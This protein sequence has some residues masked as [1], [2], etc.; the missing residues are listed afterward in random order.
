MLRHGFA[1][2]V[3]VNLHRG[4]HSGH[5]QAGEI[6]LTCRALVFA[7]VDAAQHRWRYTQLFGAVLAGIMLPSLAYGSRPRRH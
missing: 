5:V 2:L 1:V 3:G 6:R 7:D 4:F